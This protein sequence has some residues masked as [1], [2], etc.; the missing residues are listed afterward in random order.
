MVFC[1]GHVS[2][3]SYSNPNLNALLTPNGKENVPLPD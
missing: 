2:L 1:D 3:I